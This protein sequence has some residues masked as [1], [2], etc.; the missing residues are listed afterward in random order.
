MLD[1]SSVGKAISARESKL[2]LW[3]ATTVFTRLPS[4]TAV[5]Y[6]SGGLG[7]GTVYM[8]LI[9]WSWV[10]RDFE[11]CAALFPHSFSELIY[12]VYEGL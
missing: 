5:T 8:L 3:G 7:V 9:Y 2:A 12:G 1:V 4:N 10:D 6:F 11:E